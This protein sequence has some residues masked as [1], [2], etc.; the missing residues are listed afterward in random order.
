MSAIVR[1]CLRICAVELLRADP[2]IAAATAG[3]SRVF[4][5][6]MGAIDG[7]KPLPI[8]IVN[9]ENDAGE[10]WEAI[11][12]GPPFDTK[13]NLVFEIAHVAKGEQNGEPGLFFP[14]TDREL[15]AAIDFIEWRIEEA[16]AFSETPLGLAFCG[17]VL[18]RITHRSSDRFSSDDPGVRLASRV[19]TLSIETHEA[20]QEV[21]LPGDTLPA[22]EF[23]SLPEPLR[24][25][26]SLFPAG[27]SAR[28]TLELVAQ[29]IAAP[30]AS[31]L[32]EAIDLTTDPTP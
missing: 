31:D 17:K 1:L 25:M 13:I 29:K 9:S 27:S 21:W 7:E 12:G 18:K 28:E 23:A 4:D 11:N 6:E 3:G 32:F 16:L 19:L 20:D 30:A 15:E 26:A 24:S 14:V 22:G 10:A 8:I 5:S 2:A